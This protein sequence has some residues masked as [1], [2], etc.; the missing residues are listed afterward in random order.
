MIRFLGSQTVSQF[1]VYQNSS[2]L[3]LWQISKDPLFKGPHKDLIGTVAV[4][5]GVGSLL[6]GLSFYVVIG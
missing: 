1:S 2:L 5:G 6:F 4:V 3:F